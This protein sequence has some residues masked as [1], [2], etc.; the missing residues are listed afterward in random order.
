MVKAMSDKNYCPIQNMLFYFS[1]LNH[2]TTPRNGLATTVGLKTPWLRA[3][4][5]D[6]GNSLP[7]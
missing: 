3:S 2:L 5:L 6:A 4:G 7:D 1:L